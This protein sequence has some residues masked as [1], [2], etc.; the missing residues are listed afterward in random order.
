[1]WPV[2]TC[3]P[4]AGEHIRLAAK[5]ARAAPQHLKLLPLAPLGHVLHSKTWLAYFFMNS[6]E[7]GILDGMVIT[8]W[9]H[10]QLGHCEHAM[11]TMVEP[12]WREPAAEHVKRVQSLG[13]GLG[14]NKT[15]RQPAVIEGVGVTKLD[16]AKLQNLQG[17]A[18]QTCCMHAGSLCF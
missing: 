4:V 1:M 6:S 17:A 5:G 11:C 10:L 16:Q 8:Q 3:G 12:L 9:L 13:D 7:A 18:S 14:Y 15:S 2:P